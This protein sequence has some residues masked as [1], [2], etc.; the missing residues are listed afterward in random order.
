MACEDMSEAEASESSEV[1]VEDIEVLSWPA[2]R[3]G[4]VLFWGTCSKFK[5][6]NVYNCGY[7]PWDTNLIV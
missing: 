5:T 7:A 3:A 4:R 6:E 2:S 1:V